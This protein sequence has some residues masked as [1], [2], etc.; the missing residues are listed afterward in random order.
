MTR[1]KRLGRPRSGFSLPS[2]SVLKFEEKS[3]V[4]AGAGGEGGGYGGGGGEGGGSSGV[5]GGGGGEGRS[6]SGGDGGGGYWC[7]GPV[8][9]PACGGLG[10]GE[11]MARTSKCKL[12]KKLASGTG[13]PV[14]GVFDCAKTLGI[15]KT[16]VISVL[17]PA[18]SEGHPESIVDRVIPN[19]TVTATQ[20]RKCVLTTSGLITPN[21]TLARPAM[22]NKLV[23]KGVFTHPTIIDIVAAA[24]TNCPEPPN[25][26][27]TAF[28]ECVRATC[29]QSMPPGVSALPTFSLE[30][31]SSKEKE[32]DD[33]D[34]DD[35][36][37]D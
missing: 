30:D 21:G 29:I 3:V 22:V 5:G 25:L 6:G 31:K 11:C 16:Q 20:F 2:T 28:L 10:P 27:M 34:D 8:Q 35:D 26:K 37:D 33:D 24:I 9:D 15:P 19:D 14:K 32:E 12:V 18:F 36:D 17:G 4:M 13:G 7:L 1:Y 23:S